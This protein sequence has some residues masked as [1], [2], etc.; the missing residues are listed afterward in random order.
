MVILI[1][2]YQSRHLNQERS[3][4]ENVSVNTGVMMPNGI[5]LDM[6]TPTQ[7]SP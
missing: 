2:L 7:Y 4:K 3:Y 1:F 5:K 6:S